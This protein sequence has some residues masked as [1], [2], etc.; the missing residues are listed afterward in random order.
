MVF[1]SD[2]ADS[3]KLFPT[4]LINLKEIEN[5]N[6]RRLKNMLTNLEETT[7]KALIGCFS[8]RNDSILMWSHYGDSHKGVCLEFEVNEDDFSNIN[9][10][11]KKC[12]FN[13]YPI[14]ESIL[15]SDY[16]GNNELYK[17]E[18]NNEIALKPFLVKAKDWSYE[19]EVRFLCSLVKIDTLPFIK[20]DKDNNYLILKMTNIF[21]GTKAN[22]TENLKKLY[23][24]AKSKYHN[25]NI[26]YMKLSDIEYKIVPDIKRT[27]Q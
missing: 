17:S 10:S 24:T 7:S 6:K 16:L 20:H 25:I 11:D 3:Y 15:K 22:A 18:E 23:S 8:K 13:I 19:E 4:F 21:I 5:K 26:V 14:I 27:F 1:S 12:F 9:Y 2:L